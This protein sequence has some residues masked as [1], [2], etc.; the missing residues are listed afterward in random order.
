VHAR[1][2]R[3]QAAV[4]HSTMRLLRAALP[5]VFAACTL[6]A[7]DSSPP[8]A[9]DDHGDAIALDTGGEPTRFP[10]VIH[11]GFGGG[12]DGILAYY[13]VAERLR[14]DGHVVAQTEVPPF[15]TIAVRADYLRA[16]VDDTLAATGA[17][18]VNLITHSLGGLDAR[19]LIA[20]LGYGDR[21]A[22]LT[23]VSTPH[24]GTAAADFALA[25]V[26]G[27]ADPVVD[28]L[29]RLFGAKINEASDQVDVRGALTDLSEARADAFN[30]AN[31]DDPRV[32]YQSW[33]GVS[34]PLGL[35]IEQLRPDVIDACQG[36]L[37]MAPGRFDRLRPIYVPI[38]PIVGGSLFAPAPN[39]GLV[40][41][42][43]ARWGHFRGCLPADHSEEVG[44]YFGTQ[45]PNRDTGFDHL[46]FYRELAFELAELGY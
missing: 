35:G 41:V 7:E 1:R 6:P 23:T 11:H 43:S 29:A 39:D 9:L 31:P 5:L 40:A 30:A 46:R 2:L 27:H 15:D 12:H 22:S 24:Q 37:L 14:E 3:Y 28:A 42:E 10:I 18:R 19:Y 44:R 36:R 26:P 33:A 32:Y 4:H 21:I 17:E 8:A 45:G 16:V 25:V 38:A 13:L 20:S 34:S